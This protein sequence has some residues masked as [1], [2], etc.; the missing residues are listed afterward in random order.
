MKKM[1][2]MSNVV[3][4]LW[5]DFISLLFPRLCCGCGTP[6]I[7]NET[8]LCLDCF[9]NMPRTNY[10]FEKDNPVEKLFWGICK[11]EKAS[12]FSF[13]TQDSRIRKIVHSL[14]YKGM[15][16]IGPMLGKMCAN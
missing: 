5:D 7:K 9:F 13:Y 3:L 11:I 8:F 16:D 1:W 10:H 4:D 14:K 2:Y 6:L 15:M 12:A